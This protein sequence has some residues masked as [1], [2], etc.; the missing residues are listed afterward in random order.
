MANETVVGRVQAEGEVIASIA[1]PG[2]RGAA[3]GQLRVSLDSFEGHEYISIRLWMVGDDGVA[4][5]SK[6]GT[7]VRLGEAEAVADAIREAKGKARLPSPSN[8]TSQ[9]YRHSAGPP[10][11]GRRLPGRDARTP[12]PS[13]EPVARVEGGWFAGSDLRP[14]K[15]RGPERPTILPDDDRLDAEERRR[16]QPRSG[17]SEEAR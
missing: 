14:P 8:A 7:S 13:P 2:Y 10:P 9:S 4:R 17:P 11:P 6:K 3:G 15:R 12:D 16:T 1:R 5:P